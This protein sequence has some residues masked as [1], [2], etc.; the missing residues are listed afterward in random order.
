MMERLIASIVCLFMIARVGSVPV[1]RDIISG[2]EFLSILMKPAGDAG[3]RSTFPLP[4]TADQTHPNRGSRKFHY[5]LLYDHSDDDETILPIEALFSS[6]ETSGHTRPLNAAQNDRRRLPVASRNSKALTGAT[7]ETK[8][9]PEPMGATGWQ[10]LAEVTT[11]ESA[12]GAEKEEPSESSVLVDHPTTVIPTEQAN[13]TEKANEPSSSLLADRRRVELSVE[14]TSPRIATAEGRET[15]TVKDN[16]SSRSVVP[17]SSN[18]HRSELSVEEVEPTDGNGSQPATEVGTEGPSLADELVAGSQAHTPSAAGSQRYRLQRQQQNKEPLQTVIYHDK[19]PDGRAA[20]AKSVSYSFLGETASTLKTWRDINAEYLPAV[21]SKGR[22]GPDKQMGTLETTTPKEGVSPPG[23]EAR[24]EPE[25]YSQ[26]AKFYST[27]AQFYS[28]PAKIYSEPAQV[29]GVPESVYS[30][31]AKVYSEPAKVY[32]EPAKVY[33]EPAKVY[34][35][36]AKVYSQPSS[37]WQMVYAVESTTVAPSSGTS[38]GP[39]LVLSGARAQKTKDDCKVTASCDEQ[40][41]QQQR[42][43][44]VFNELDK[45]PYDQLNAPVKGDAYVIQDVIGRFVPK[46]RIKGRNGQGAG[47]QTSGAAATEA[48]PRTPLAPAGVAGEDSKIGYVVEGRNYR[49]Y[50]VEEKTPDGFIVG[51]YGVLSHN[52]GNLRGVRYTA[53]SDINPRLI[54]DTLLKFLSL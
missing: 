4:A 44:Y 25:S 26:P 41:Q 27:P 32:S 5:G 38:T 6:Q 46:Q 24:A 42:Q 1:P 43:R 35:E 22:K 54:Y 47:S 20:P 3:A 16:F 28:E 53:D 50:R 34:S 31:P 15:T 37:Y 17:Q 8:L 14:D 21:S 33:S 51:E 30:V 49:K 13:E 11:L 48:R 19:R 9:T 45:I 29:Y 40:S 7:G 10:L 12:E 36:P 18:S 39:G 2:K 52:D 23:A